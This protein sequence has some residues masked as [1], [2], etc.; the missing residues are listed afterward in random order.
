MSLILL[1][2]GA[3]AQTTSNA[4]IEMADGMVQSDVDQVPLI[5]GIGV[6]SLI[7]EEYSCGTV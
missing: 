6:A 5:N 1:S 2:A 3:F 7:A 4:P